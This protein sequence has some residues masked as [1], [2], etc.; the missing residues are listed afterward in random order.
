[1]NAQEVLN[2]F[3]DKKL[4]VDVLSI[5]KDLGLNAYSL[6]DEE[7]MQGV[8][9]RYDSTSGVPAVFVNTQEP[10]T[11]Q[12]FTL[13]HELGHFCL[14]HGNSFRDT[15]ETLYSYDH[16]E[17]SANLFAADLLMPE[18]YVK[19]YIFSEG[20]TS[21]AELADIFLVSYSAM[22]IRLERLGLL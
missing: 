7:I 6:S 22:K 10:L 19:H 13:A 9:G 15:R 4:P 18:D 2:K 20:I 16:K 21:V 12:R 11:R 3:W 1:M 5:V 14:N 8:S 17:Y